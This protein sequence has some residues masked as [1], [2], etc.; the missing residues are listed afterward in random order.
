MRGIKPLRW[1]RD[2]DYRY[3]D[4]GLWLHDWAWEFLRR[5]PDYI[6]AYDKWWAAK[7]GKVKVSRATET[8]RMV[9]AGLAFGLLTPYD[10]DNSPIVYGGINWAD[11]TSVFIADQLPEGSAGGES[12]RWP[13]YPEIAL[14]Q[15]RLDLP[16]D[17]QLQWAKR[18]LRNAAAWVQDKEGVEVR[19]PNIRP[20]VGRFPIYLRMLDG[21]KAGASAAEM[22]R[23]FLSGVDP[24]SAGRK[25]LKQAR[26]MAR[27]DYRQLL[28]YPNR[29]C[30]GKETR[31]KS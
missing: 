24:S 14:L 8:R 6:V 26:K 1:D 25:A 5:N 7:S 2:E 18:R 29:G 12:S 28:L 10:P 3:L 4:G 16:I 27:R 17:A 11:S 20:Q 9:R 15:F 19:K 23:R 13:G 22:G 31:T 21:A 30:G